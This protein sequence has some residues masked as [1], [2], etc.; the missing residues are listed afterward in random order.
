VTH[1]TNPELDL[2]E[3]PNSI[4][5]FGAVVPTLAAS[6]TTAASPFL[7]EGEFGFADGNLRG[8]FDRVALCGRIVA[9]GVTLEAASAVNF[10]A[11][12][13]LIR[14]EVTGPNGMCIESAIV[15]PTLPLVAVQWSGGAGTGLKLHL[16]SG[17]GGGEYN[18]DRNVV[19]A[20]NA[21]DPDFCVAV[22]LHGANGAWAVRPS[23]EGRGLQLAHDLVPNGVITLVIAAGRPEQVRSAF[24]AVAHVNAHSVRATSPADDVLYTVTGLPEIDD[25]VAWAATRLRNALAECRL[26]GPV[27]EAGHTNAPHAFWAGMGALASGDKDSALRAL[28]LLMDAENGGEQ[29]A[30][31]APVLADLLAARI[32]LGTGDARYVRKRAEG[33]LLEPGRLSADHHDLGTLTIDNIADA[34]RYSE[35]AEQIASV[36]GLSSQIAP[37]GGRRRLPMAGVTSSTEIAFLA[38]ALRHGA[39]PPPTGSLELDRMVSA[40]AEFPSYPETAWTAWRGALTEGLKS[41]PGGPGSWDGAEAATGIGA[42]VAGALLSALV[43]GLL[44]YLPDAPSGRTRLAPSFPAHLTSFGVSGLRLGDAQIS[45][46]YEREGAIHRFKL[47]PKVARVPPVVL[48]EPLLPGGRL[49][50]ARVDGD[51]AELDSTPARDGIRARIQVP[52]DGDR[53]I[54]FFT[55]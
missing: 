18:L 11:T 36:R 48:L 14:R 7:I 27:T 25:G 10:V 37:V 31:P 6:G 17:D 40:W 53:E 8:G 9:E 21:E 30:W 2:P 4:P 29:E 3:L 26:S 34:L 33:L 49:T 55:E 20:R 41:G 12:P 44:G 51:I 45:M 52:L 13:G 15:A 23:D 38:G 39:S 24:N 16:P 19:V 46:H 22:G 35:S 54:E 1:R 32:G 43:Y 47:E 28:A 5:D 42:P 50:A